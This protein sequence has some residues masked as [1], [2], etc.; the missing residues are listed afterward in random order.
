M[1]KT[2]EGLEEV[3]KVELVR[4]LFFARLS[5]ERVFANGVA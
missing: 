3:E 5:S 1:E 4:C 2:L